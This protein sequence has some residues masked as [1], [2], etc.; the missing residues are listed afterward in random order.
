[1]TETINRPPRLRLP[2][3]LM[4]WPL[5]AFFGVVILYAVSTFIFSTLSSDGS[6][7]VPAPDTVKSVVNVILFVVAVATIIG[8]PASFIVGLVLLLSAQRAS[9]DP[10]ATNIVN[11][12]KEVIPPDTDGM[13]TAGL[14]IGVLG[15][16]TAWIYLGLVLGV[17]GICLSAM[18]YR[19][20]R[21]KGIAIIGLATSIV[22]VIIGLVASIML[23]LSLTNSPQ[24]RYPS[25]P[26]GTLQDDS[27]FIESNI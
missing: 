19:R 22:A 4:A 23:A 5:V 10:E 8:G 26:Q 27:Q 9:N 13:A 20:S 25:Y 21:R 2:I 16:M 15:M 1:M 24:T 11:K 7:H 14:V 6:G 18:G 3:A 17:T 12:S